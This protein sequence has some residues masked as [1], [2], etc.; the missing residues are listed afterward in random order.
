MFLE[1]LKKDK[2]FLV[3]F[4]LLVLAAILGISLGAAALATKKSEFPL[5]AKFL[6]WFKEKRLDKAP[7]WLKSHCYTA[8]VF[9]IITL[10]VGI[11]SLVVVGLSLVKPELLPSK[12]L[13]IVGVVLAL[14]VIIFGSVA[15]QFAKDVVNPTTTNVHSMG[16]SVNHRIGEYWEQI[17][18]RAGTG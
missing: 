15:V 7:S 12:V 11:G 14:V 1:K 18:G 5:E 17:S 3:G 4:G 10:L 16:E 6:D 2:L 8:L 13:L 9:A